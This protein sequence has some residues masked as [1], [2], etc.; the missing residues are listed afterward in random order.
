MG[1]WKNKQGKRKDKQDDWINKAFSGLGEEDVL[2]LSEIHAGVHANHLINEK[3]K[4]D[5]IDRA[6]LAD[7][8][9]IERRRQFKKEQRRKRIIRICSVCA[10]LIAVIAILAF[11][12]V[13]DREDLRYYKYNIY[14]VRNVK[15]NVNDEEWYEKVLDYKLPDYL[16]VSEDEFPEI[17]KSILDYTMY[18]VASEYCASNDFVLD[19]Y[20]VRNMSKV[21]TENNEY[22]LLCEMV[23]G[24]YDIEEPVDEVSDDLMP[25][26]MVA[27][28][29]ERVLS[30]GDRIAGCYFCNV[31]RNDALYR[32]FFVNVE[33]EDRGYKILVE[34]QRGLSR[35]GCGNTLFSA[36]WEAP[37]TTR[38]K[39]N[40]KM[41]ENKLYTFD[42]EVTG[43]NITFQMKFEN[44]DLKMRYC[45]EDEDIE[46]KEFYN[47][48]GA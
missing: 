14:D 6:Q 8:A 31:E 39:V 35:L 23:L 13:F 3:I 26:F 22:M 38:F 28:N 2:W 15:V 16:E 4:W 27:V 40:K 19:D 37:I 18:N 33:L 36:G 10:A 17:D 34:D 32:N 42:K 30:T 43:G 47:L 25:V 41:E 12:G 1:F 20:V 48:A 5:V 11:A 44:G 7:E 29:V 21:K 46:N 9:E 24:C 45:I